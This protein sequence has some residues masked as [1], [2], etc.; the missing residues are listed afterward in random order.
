[1]DYILITGG[2][3]YIGSHVVIEFIAQGFHVI[4][5]DKNVSNKDVYDALCKITSLESILFFPIDLC[6]ESSVS[7]IFMK[8][9]IHWVIHMAGLKSV[10]ES[11]A[12]PLDYYTNNVCGTMN[13]LNTMKKFQC[14]NL[15]F[16]SSATVYGNTHYPVDEESQTGLGISSPYGQTKYMI[17]QILKDVARDPLW[18][19][20]I[21]RYFNPIGHHPL[22]PIESKS[23]NLFPVLIKSV[24]NNTGFTIFGNDYDTIDGTCIRDFIHVQDVAR[25]HTAA[26]IHITFQG[27][28]VYNLGCGQGV[29]VLQF[30][31]CFERVNHVKIDYHFGPRREGDLPIIFA[32]VQRV[33]TDLHWTTEKTL[34]EGVKM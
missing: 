13:L 4:I 21:L 30:I 20:V 29:S 2:L 27:Y 1:M 8:Y 14:H 12:Q 31:Q 32:N 34:E 26:M 9:K 7:S 23:T 16:S 17:E 19:I 22:L 6:D 10:P 28:H 3:G 24:R 15:I 11:I 5:I 18:T 25:G 33:K